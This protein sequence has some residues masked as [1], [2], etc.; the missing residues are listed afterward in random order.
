MA[1]SRR[2]FFYGSL[3][4]GAVPAVGFGSTPSLKSAGYKSPNEKVNFAAIGSGGQGAGNIAAA[5]P[6]ENIVAL[7]DVDDRRAAETFTRF[8]NAP[9]FRDFRQMLDKEGKNIDAVIVAT[10]DH[11]HAT[12]AMWCM[13]RG[14]HVYVQK[15]LVRTI[16]EARQLREAAAK[17]KVATQMGN[18]GYSNEGTRQC[19]EMIWNGEIGNVTEVHAWSDRPM[20]PQGLTEIPKEDPVPSTLDWDL[21]LGVAEKRPFTAGGKTEPDRNGGFFYNPFN[22]RGFYDFG[23]GALGDMACHILGAPNMALHLSNRK[24]VSV[25]C[26]KK[27]GTSPFMFPKASVL[28]FDFAPYGNMP[29]LKVFWYDGLKETPKISGVPEGEWLGDPPMLAGAAGGRGPGMRAAGNNFQSPGRVFNQEDFDALKAATTPLR[30][31]QP[32]GSLFVGD[33]GMLTTGT[34][35]DVTRL[36][37]IEKMKDYQMPAPLLTRSPGHMRDFIRA[38]KGGDPACSN[39]EVAAP[40]VEWMLLGV[41]ALRHEGKLEYDPEKMRITNNSDANKLLKPTFRKGWEFHTV[42]G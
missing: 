26:V 18:Q 27:E 28:R 33:K 24:V 35:G 2:Y 17:Y 10:P 1:I 22:W 8:P 16:W 36:I 23:C 5:A 39:F 38:C 32:D 7:C 42:K 15:P 4:A 29:A 41:I 20:W 37:P 25:E 31:P 6:T 34:Y 40:F 21:W 12:A 13:E 30:F 3:L 14:K 11:M 19:A 9:K